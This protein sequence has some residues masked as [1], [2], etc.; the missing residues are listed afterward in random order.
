M[1]MISQYATLERSRFQGNSGKT[2]GC[3]SLKRIQYRV[4]RRL[5]ADQKPGTVTDSE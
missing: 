5:T 1:G 3:R 4:K 2:E